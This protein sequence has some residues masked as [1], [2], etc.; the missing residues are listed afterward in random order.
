M[1]GYVIVHATIQN[2]VMAV[3]EMKFYRGREEEGGCWE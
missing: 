1:K 3:S 2:E